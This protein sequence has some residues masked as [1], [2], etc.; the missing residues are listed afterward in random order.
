[1]GL[2]NWLKKN[3][4]NNET[5]ANLNFL[6]ERYEQ[7][8]NC[9]MDS[10]E[11]EFRQAVYEELKRNGGIG[12]GSRGALFSVNLYWGNVAYDKVTGKKHVAFRT[13]KKALFKVMFEKPDLELSFLTP[14]HIEKHRLTDIKLD[15][16]KWFVKALEFSDKG[17]DGQALECYNKAIVAEPLDARAWNNKGDLLSKFGKYSKALKCF[18]KALDI[19]PRIAGGKV[20]SNKAAV[21]EKLGRYEEALKCYD[22][23]LE[24]D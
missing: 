16:E 3:E 18:D 20:W 1:M 6:P 8:L 7:G 22:K 12:R 24:K 23:A 4:A 13:T 17:K 11:P 15:S 9:F 21:L 10:V 14:G 2:F 19:A 5:K